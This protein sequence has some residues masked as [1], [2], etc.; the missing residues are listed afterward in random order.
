ML[1]MTKWTLVRVDYSRN[2]LVLFQNQSVDGLGLQR[3]LREAGFHFQD[4]RLVRRWAPWTT[5]RDIHGHFVDGR[6]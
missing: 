6:S 3:T 4:S 2:V 5:A 1:G